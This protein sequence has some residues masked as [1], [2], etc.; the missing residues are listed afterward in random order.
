MDL[1][2][3]EDILHLICEELRQRQDFATLFNCAVSSKQLAPLALS[4]LYR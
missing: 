4:N 1:Q 2:L 3:P